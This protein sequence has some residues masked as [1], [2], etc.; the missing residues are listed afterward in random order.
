MYKLSLATMTALSLLASLPAAAQNVDGGGRLIAPPTRAEM[1]TDQQDQ[2]GQALSNASADEIAQAQQALNEKGFR[3]GK[4][5]GK[6]GR[7]TTMALKRFQ[8]KQGLESSGEL[9]NQTAAALGISDVTGAPPS[10]NGNGGN[11][12]GRRSRD[13][14]DR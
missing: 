6:M 3:A 12:N 7:Q 13:Q 2:S 5:D 9:D 14:T 10:T 1:Q 4:P 11:S 8:Q